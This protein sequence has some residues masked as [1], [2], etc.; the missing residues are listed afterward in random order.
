[1]TIQTVDMKMPQRAG[2]YVVDCLR[3]NSDTRDIPVFVLTGQRQSHVAVRMR[4]L[5]VAEFF[6]KPVCFDELRE[7]MEKHIPL[8]ER[9]WSAKEIAAGMT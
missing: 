5:G 4:Q 7:A 8:R 2:E 6:T 3:H 1:M 9:D